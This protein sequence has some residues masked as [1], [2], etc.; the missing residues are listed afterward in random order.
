MSRP[1][2]SLSL[3]LDNKWSYL[4]TRGDASWRGLPSY[5]DL[6]VPRILA[7]TES[8]DLWITVFVVGQD[9]ALDK[10]R[11]AIAA[12]ADAG[13]EI[14]NHSFHHE[15]WLHRYT[16]GQVEAEVK[17]AEEH[18]HRITGQ[19][20]VGFR[21]PGY[22]CSDATLRV[23][24]GRGY[25]YDASVL[26][27]FLGPLARA[28][29]FLTAKLDRKEKEKR[30]AL[31]G[32]LRDGLQPLRPHLRN[33][34]ETSI[35][36]I[37]VTTMPWLKLP[38]HVSYLLYLR[39]F[40]RSLAMSYFRAAVTLCRWAGIGPSLLLHPLDFMDA[41]DEPDLTFFPAM[42]LPRAEKL[43]LVRDVVRMLGD[44]YQIVTMRQ[45]AEHARRTF[46]LPADI[47]VTDRRAAGR[48]ATTPVG[49]PRE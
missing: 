41:D 49:A 48:V 3:D 30:K 40:S 43:T 9:A 17:A 26:P 45:H 22:S 37:P 42:R 21:G 10:N 18:I 47:P 39:R 27:T 4:K 32:R 31:F 44:R 5:L 29:Y 25:L 38:I 8:M 34:G 7:L 20:P 11:R 13:H 15:P 46:G 14:A 2:A 12:I 6:V 24:S 1:I 36:E 16:E 23:L 35:L 28:Y 33:T 19:Q